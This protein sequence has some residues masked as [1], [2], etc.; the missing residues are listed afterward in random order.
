M[1]K[2]ARLVREKY[3]AIIAVVVLMVA[4]CLLPAQQSPISPE[5]YG[6]LKYRYIGP[7]GN[8]AT[9]VA[10]VPGRPNIW[11]V[12]A[13]S[14]GIFKSR[15]G[16]IHWDPIFDSEAVASIGSLAVAASDQNILWA[17]TGE[18]FIRSHISVG[19]GIYKSMDA[20]KTWSLMGLEKVGRIGRVEID[21]RNPDVVLACALGHA[22]GP[23]P[24]RGV[25]RTADG[26][27]NW[28]MVN[29][30]R[31]LRGRTH[32]YTRT[33][34]APDNENEVFF[35]SASFSRTLDG[36]H[37]LTKMP[38]NP[39]GDNH[40]MWIDPT[41]G[42]RMAVVND[43]GVNISVNRG[44]SWNHVNLPIAQIYHVTVD[45]QIPYSV[46]GN[47]QDGPSWRGPSNS[48][49]FGGYSGN[50]IPRGAWHPVAGGESGFAMPDPADNN[51]IWSTGTGS[52][53]I[54]GTVT[55]FDER[56]HQ[57]R[58]VEVWPDYVAGAPAAEVKY[59]FNWEFP[60]A[61]SPHDHNKVYVGSQFVH[62]TTD[63]GN[64]WQIISPDLTRNDKSR[65][66]I[67]GGLTPDNIGVEYAGV[68]FAL[69]ES[70]KEAGLIWVGTNDGLVQVTRDGGKNWSNVTKNLPDLPEWVTVDN[71]E[72][73]RY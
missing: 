66:Q 53:S 1:L 21:P 20:G 62:V 24:E 37:T 5:V 39:G 12:G 18:S 57:N 17:G 13:A 67:S 44:S 59:R 7:E 60:I 72:A 73:S 27:E 41:D 51:I 54:G 29:S 36:G 69:T 4:P 33:E 26:G 16:G 47:R 19:Q 56:T 46:Y 65:Q 31:Q 3:V 15:D 6:Q 50:S 9:A 8:R 49:Q 28:E 61:I 48:L 71:I 40:E 64:S 45:D 35:F 68:I 10:G 42:D 52:G 38:S 55:R 58:E 43:G 34:I 23:Q 2:L 32:Y 70:P 22:Y 30:D 14:G 11:Y 25:F 63:G